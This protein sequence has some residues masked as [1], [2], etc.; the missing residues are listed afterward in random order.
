MVGN[1]WDYLTSMKDKIKQIRESIADIRKTLTKYG[2]TPERYDDTTIY[3]SGTTPP[4]YYG[5][6]VVTMSGINQ[7]ISVSGSTQG[8][9]SSSPL[10][11][12]IPPNVFSFS[13]LSAVHDRSFALDIP[14]EAELEEKF[15]DL[16]KPELL[17]GNI[18]SDEKSSK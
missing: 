6:V 1:R 2:K 9:G 11:T 18:V 17:S 10:V 4:S 5:S 3:I 12:L 13:D 16:L 7:S 14:T 8:G 15:E